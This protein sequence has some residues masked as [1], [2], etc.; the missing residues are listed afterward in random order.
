MCDGMFISHVNSIINIRA[1][2]QKNYVY[3]RINLFYARVTI[4]RRLFR[5]TIMSELK[6]VT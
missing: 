1:D 2:L 5:E 3:N 6:N 4:Y